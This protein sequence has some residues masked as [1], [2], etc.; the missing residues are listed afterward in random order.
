MDYPNDL[1]QLTPIYEDFATLVAREY[2]V[3]V[4]AEP[5][6]V[7]DILREMVYKVLLIS[8]YQTDD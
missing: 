3:R 1:H 2:A 6:K 8:H 4:L 7:I 5:E